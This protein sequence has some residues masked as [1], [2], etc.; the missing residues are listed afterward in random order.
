VFV[1]SSEMCPEGPSGMMAGTGL[2]AMPCSEPKGISSGILENDDF[3]IFYNQ[4]S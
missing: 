1:V 2:I 3:V 4:L